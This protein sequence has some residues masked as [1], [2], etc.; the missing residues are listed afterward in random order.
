MAAEN[1]K[2][3]D[4]EIGQALFS[5]TERFEM[6][7]AAYWKPVTVVAVILAVLTAVVFWVATARSAA[8]R[9]AAFE[10]ADAATE[11]ELTAVLKK[12]PDH[13]GSAVAR[14]RLAKLF[15]DAKK[16]QEALKELDA[17][18]N[19]SGADATLAAQAKMAAGYACELSNNIKDAIP[20]FL[21]VESAIA[22]CPVEAIEKE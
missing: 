5:D 10:L 3:I 6:W 1:N 14:F 22:S 18:A 16:Y 4:S 9:K 17:F 7:F 13:A 19:A 11:A 20:R 8:E 15:L 12:Y 21:A 2:K